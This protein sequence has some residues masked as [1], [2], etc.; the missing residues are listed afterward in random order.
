MENADKAQGQETVAAGPID[1]NAFLYRNPVWAN[2]EHT[3]IALDV[4]WRETDPWMPYGTASFDPEP[5]GRVFFARVVEECG[6]SIGPYV[7]PPPSPYT[8]YVSDFWDRMT[9]EEG[10]D[11]DAAMSIATPLKSRRAFNAAVTLQ[12]DSDLFAWVRNVLLGV[13]TEARAAVIMAQ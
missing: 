3:A 10:D 7:P 13:T 4:R 12:S 11:F 2:E 9:V 8:L 5:S 1:I 6:D